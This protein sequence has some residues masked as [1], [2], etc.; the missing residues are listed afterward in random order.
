MDFAITENEKR[1]GFVDPEKLAAIVEQIETIGFAA[2]TNVVSQES[3]E[4]HAQAIQDDV[5]KVRASGTKTAHERVTGEGHLQLGLRRFAPYVKADLVANPIIENVIAAVL[6]RGAWLGFYS[7]NVNCGG[8]TY[9]PLHYDRPFSWTT[10]EAA[11]KAGHSWPPPPTSLGCSIALEDITLDNGATEIYPGTHN[12]TETIGLLKGS[13]LEDHPALLEKWGPA[14]RMPI[15][16]GGVVIRDP[17]MWHRGVPNSSSRA[18]AMIAV[19]YHSPICKHWRGLLVDDDTK[20]QACQ[21]PDQHVMDDGSIGDGRLVFQADSRDVFES[22]DNLH[23][24]ERNV[25]FVDDHWRVNHLADSHG[26]GGAR[27]VD[28]NDSAA[29]DVVT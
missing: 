7:G 16:A 22:A 14:D 26:I 18:R 20:T 27:V 13:R 11:A 5:K 15:P 2:L 24:I 19:T 9:Q 10:P 28:A 12:A 21:N 29:I 3:C 6:G 17:R 1:S 8:S 25:R 4:L 23:G